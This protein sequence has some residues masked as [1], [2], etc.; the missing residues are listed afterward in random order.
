MRKSLN[1]CTSRINF[2]SGLAIALF[3]V[4][5]TKSHAANGSWNVDTD[6]N[7]ST[8]GNW[9]GNTIADG[10]G[11]T[12][13]FTNGLTAIHTVTL[14]SARTNANLVFDDSNAAVNAGG[15]ILTGSGLT[16]SNSAATPVITV[17][18]ISS[19]GGLDATND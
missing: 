5:L 14:D 2:K 17:N 8:P 7:W 4:A 13:Y 15:W 16:L 12:A 19:L 9:L 1:S 10:P 3:C 11:S 18:P 6:G